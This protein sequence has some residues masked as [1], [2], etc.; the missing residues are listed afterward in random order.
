MLKFSNEDYSVPRDRMRYQTGTGRNDTM[1]SDIGKF[2]CDG[3]RNSDITGSCGVKLPESCTTAA[4]A[5]VYSPYQQYTEVFDSMTALSNGT[6]FKEL[7][8][9]FKGGACNG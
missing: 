7:Y 3:T 8:K 2:R 1:R 5:S 9:P 6:L 4:L